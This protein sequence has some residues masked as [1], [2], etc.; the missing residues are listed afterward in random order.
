[1]AVSR[2]RTLYFGLAGAL[3]VVA[4]RPIGIVDDVIDVAVLPAR[5]LGELALPLTFWHERVAYAGNSIDDTVRV[6]EQFEREALEHAVFDSALSRR[7]DLPTGVRGLHGEVVARARN[8]LDRIVVRVASD[9]A[10][11]PGLPVVSGDYFVGIVEAVPAADGLDWVEI[12]VQLVTDADARIGGLI[13]EDQRGESC[14][15]VVG[16]LAPRSDRIDLDLHNPSNRGSEAGSILVY[17]APELVDGP[18]WLANGFM[19]GELYFER[20]ERATRRGVRPGLDYQTGLYQVLVLMPEE[21]ES[22]RVG[23][24]PSFPDDWEPVR[25][26]LRADPSAWRDGRK[27]SIGRLQGIDVGAAVASGIRMIGRVAHSSWLSADVR[28]V[29]DRGFRVNALALIGDGESERPHVMG[30][31]RSLGRDEHGDLL[32]EW[33]TVLPLEYGGGTDFVEA[34]LFTGS[35]ERGVPRGLLLG[36]AVLPTGPGPHVFSV[37]QPEGAR[38]PV[39]LLVF[40]ST[41]GVQ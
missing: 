11:R 18:S 21:V 34:R 16:G 35:G 1:M 17:E 32:F 28:L 38:E 22:Q 2:S 10:L 14:Q 36:D 27:L 29:G 37:R 20:D 24:L 3:A 31:V 6:R 4:V 12:E 30:R 39:D 40:R 8:D 26:M 23:A 13:D 15:L 7:F 33:P 9:P 19:L 41:E 25:F 5:V